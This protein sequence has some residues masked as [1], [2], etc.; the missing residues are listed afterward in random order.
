MLLIVLLCLLAAVAIAAFLHFR[1]AEATAW[2]D[3]IVD[4][5]GT[6]W[7][8]WS[9]RIAAFQFST[10]LIWWAGVPAEWKAALP[11]SAGM[12]LL[13]GSGAAFIIA[14]MVKQKNLGDQ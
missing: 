10:V 9:T 14:Q 3:H 8:R 6:L 12:L 7:K 1:R 4:D 2:R 11:A 5:V 13:A